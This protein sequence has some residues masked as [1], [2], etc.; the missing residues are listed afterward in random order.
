LEQKKILL[1]I[2]CGRKKALELHEMKL[3]AFKSYKGPMFQ[4]L[5]K[6]KREGRWSSNIYLGIISAKYGFLRS[7]D[8][9][10]YYDKRMT[11]E[12]SK[13][14]NKQVIKEIKEWYIEEKFNLIYVLMGTDYLKAVDG[15]KHHLST[16]I[17]IENMGGLGVGQ[18]KLKNFLDRYSRKD[19]SL[20]D[21]IC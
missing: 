4:V 16:E 8:E 7:T 15:L 17:I 1:I 21:N 12:L 19:S 11:P 13:Q 5:A 10:E 14:L 3:P 20:F 9:I 18:R 2:S 6:A